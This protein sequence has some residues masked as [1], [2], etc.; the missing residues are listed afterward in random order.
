MTWDLDDLFA[1]NHVEEAEVP[2]NVLII[3]CICIITQLHVQ[4]AFAEHT[5]QVLKIVWYVAYM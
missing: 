4:L 2:D 1:S 5:C 3:I